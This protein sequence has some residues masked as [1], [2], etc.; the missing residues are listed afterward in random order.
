MASAITFLIKIF[1]VKHTV[2][3]DF[4]IVTNQY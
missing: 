1:N 3:E 4:N 2:I